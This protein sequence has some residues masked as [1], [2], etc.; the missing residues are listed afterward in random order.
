MP[1]IDLLINNW[2]QHSARSIPAGMKQDLKAQGM[3]GGSG[4]P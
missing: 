4:Q 1:T 3:G 2:N